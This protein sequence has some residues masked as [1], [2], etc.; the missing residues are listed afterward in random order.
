MPVTARGSGTGLSGAC[1]ARRAG[2]IVVSLRAHERDPR[3]R[4]RQPHGRRP[5][6]R[7]RSTSSTRPSPP[8]GL[9]YPVFPGEYSASLGGN[10]NTNAGGMR[11]VKY[12]V[13]RHHVLGLEAVLA[14]GRG[15]PHR[16]QGREGH[17]RLRPHPAHHRLGGHPRPRH[18][19]D[20]QAPRPASSTRPRC[21][22]R[23][24][25]STR[26]P[27]RCPG[28]SARG[29]GPADPRVHRPDDDGRGH[30]L[31]RARPRHPRGDQGHRARL[32]GGRAG[33]PHDQ[34]RLDEDVERWWP[35]CWASSAPSTS[36]C[37]RRRPAASLIDAREKAFWVAKANSADDII[38]VVVPRA[39]IP[40][41]MAAVSR[42]R[43]RDAGRGSPAAATPA[44]ATCTCRSSSPTPTVRAGDPAQGVRGRHGPRRRHLRRARHRHR[45]AG[46]TSSSSRTRRRS[47]SCG[48]SRPPSTPT[49]SS[50]PARL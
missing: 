11:A 29:V 15:D 6:R 27:R 46:A 18:R 8:L 21:W 45:E 17:H 49:A 40:E 16:R 24:P 2:G 22:R 43:R 7:A 31:R 1:I 4:H 3:D 41:F 33:E 28:S 35:S 9:V 5:A 50:T 44:T 10:V 26:S 23:S 34:D 32:P 37:C 12:G 39:S 47:R 19:G 14:V 30:R 42:D 48:A 38:D 36:T 20:A 25:R 13:T